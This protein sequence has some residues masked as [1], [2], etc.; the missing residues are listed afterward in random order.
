M[1]CQ[2]CLFTL[3]MWL[4]K[5]ASMAWS[6]ASES[7]VFGQPNFAWSLMFWQPKRNFLNHWVTVVN[8]TV[9]P[10]NKCHW[11]VLWHYGLVWTCK[12]WMF[13]YVAFKPHTQWINTQHVNAPTTTILP[14]T[15]DTSH[16][17]NCF[18]HGIYKLLTS[19]YQ[20]IAKLLT[21][22]RNIYYRLI[23]RK[24]FKMY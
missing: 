1:K 7:M 23:Q 11:L 14:T 8:C 16:D 5:F 6:R 24:S 4:T 17:L 15:A 22:P 10:F 2:A 9:Q 19:T 12:G 20:N 3:Q 18:S 21:Q 13:I